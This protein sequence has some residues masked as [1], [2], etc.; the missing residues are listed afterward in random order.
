MVLHSGDNKSP[1]R[2]ANDLIFVPDMEN[3]IANKMRTRCYRQVSP[4][5]R[6]Y[7]DNLV[8]VAVVL[9]SSDNKSP[10]R[11]ANDLIFVP[12]IDK[13]IANK[14]HTRCY[15]QVSRFLRCYWQNLVQGQHVYVAV[16]LPSSDNKS[17]VRSANDL[18]FVPV[19]DNHIANKMHTRCYRQVS[20]FLRCYWYNLVQSLHVH[21]YR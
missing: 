12:V 8:Q 7:W 4:F 21:T 19:I 17:P 1:V 13:H 11:S 5:L 2:R 18:I 15:R 6:C 3:H 16:V 9:H 20:P 10:V 14:L